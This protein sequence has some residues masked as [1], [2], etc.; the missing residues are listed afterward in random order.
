[1]NAYLP[2]R[3]RKSLKVEVQFPGN[4]FEFGI[5]G[6]DFW[7]IQ[8]K[9]SYTEFENLKNPRIQPMYGK[10]ANHIFQVELDEILEVCKNDN[11]R[12]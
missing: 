1:M 2:K 10:I 3:P 9:A 12:E 11:R 6:N 7:A 5:I 4:W 8:I